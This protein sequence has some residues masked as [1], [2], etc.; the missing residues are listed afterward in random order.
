[1]ADIRA[2]LAAAADPQGGCTGITATWCPRCGE[3]TCVRDRS[4]A[5]SLCDP[6]C[7]LHAPGS[8]HGEPPPADTG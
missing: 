5:P 7:P 6:R 2:A 3:C 8:D 1:M 4:D